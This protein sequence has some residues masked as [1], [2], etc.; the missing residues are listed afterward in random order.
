RNL[1]APSTG[2][3]GIGYGSAVGRGKST[4]PAMILG[5]SAQQMRHVHE[6]LSKRMLANEGKGYIKSFV[7][8]QTYVPPNQEERMKIIDAIETM[9]NDPKIRT[10]SKRAGSFLK[11]MRTLSAVEPFTVEEIPAWAKRTI[12]EKDGRVGAIGFLYSTVRKWDALDVQAYQ[13]QLG[14]IDTPTGKVPLASSGFILAD[15]IRTV[16]AD[17]F[18]LMPI[19]FAVILL[20]LLID[21]RSIKGALVCLST[22]AVA[23][24][25]TIGGMVLFDIRLGLY[26]M[27]VLPMVLGTGIDGSIHIYHRTLEMG[28]DRILYVIKTTGL[29]VVAASLTTLAGF[30]GLLVVLHKGIKSIGDLAVVGILATLLAV[31]SFMPG[32]LL[33][34]YANHRPHQAPPANPDA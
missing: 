28:T 29:S 1:R 33:I 6:V 5:A 10:K 27:I 21:L 2:G 16:K 30:A 9:V 19:T 22:M 12:T 7:T 14:L 13:D 32:L 17:A 34:V 18:R 8:V 23:L 3:S 20:I 24:L 25:W 31:I 11:R 4:S 26:N 15:V